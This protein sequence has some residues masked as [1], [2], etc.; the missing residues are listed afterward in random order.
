MGRGWKSGKWI[1][2]K[3]QKSHEKLAIRGRRKSKPCYTVMECL[4]RMLPVIM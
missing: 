3:G 1:V 4:A 2:N